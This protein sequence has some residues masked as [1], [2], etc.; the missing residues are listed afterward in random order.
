MKKPL[1][2]FGVLAIVLTMLSACSNSVVK[3]EFRDNPEV[4]V[5]KGVVQEQDNGK[6]G[7]HILEVEDG[8]D[9]S[10]RSLLFNLSDDQYLGN[11]VKINAVYNTNDNVYEVTDIKV[12]DEND[13]E[14]DEKGKIVKY[15]DGNLGLELNYKD[16]WTAVAGDD[17]VTFF[18]PS[19]E[20]KKIDEIAIKQI[21]YSYQPPSVVSGSDVSP[22]D[23]NDAALLAYMN[24]TFAGDLL[25]DGSDIEKIGSERVNAISTDDGKNISYYFY[26]PGL[27]YKFSFVQNAAKGENKIVFEDMLNSLKFVPFSIENDEHSET[28]IELE[29]DTSETVSS[30]VGY[31][32]FESLLYSFEA[33]YPDQ[34]YYAGSRGSG[35]V[36]HHYGFSDESFEGGEELI[37]LDISSASM[38]SGTKVSVGGREV[39]SRSSGTNSEFYV[40]EGGYLFKFS[41]NS[42]YK[43][44]LQTMAGSLRPIEKE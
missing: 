17:S 22:S 12:L 37:S 1:K 6:L 43:A 9:E 38:P 10:L 40:S 15:K 36:L 3:D 41:G 13:E 19:S 18:S 28:G 21:V 26:R 5:L 25:F 11:L 2:A 30:E 20:D 32:S 7:T 31:T 8:D 33:K 42:K 16:S 27:I 44:V 29:A 23:T 14:L 39:V 4:V 34:W 24:K 35:S